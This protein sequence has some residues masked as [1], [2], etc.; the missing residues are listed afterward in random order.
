VT[1]AELAAAP[2]SRPNIVD[3]NQVLSRLERGL[4]QRLPERIAL[5][6]SPGPGLWHCRTD[7]AEVRRLIFDLAAAAAD[8]I[9]GDGEIIVGTRNFIFDEG[10]VADYPGARIGE[11][12]RVTIRDNGGG[13]PPGALDR[14][15]E[16]GASARPAIA[17]AEPVMR[18][19]GGYVR[20]ESAEGVGTAV[21]L[22]FGREAAPARFRFAKAAE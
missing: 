15:L 22:Y 18:S 9:D 10:S 4:R 2:P 13:F 11:F 19:L 8:E 1:A 16:P 7:P 3:L 17:I 5:R 20:V 6:L 21:H 14:I 12:V